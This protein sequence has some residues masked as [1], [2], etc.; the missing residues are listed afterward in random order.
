MFS[1]RLARWALPAL[2]T[3]V[4][5]GVGAQ[6][7]TTS[8]GTYLICRTT[9]GAAACFELGLTTAARLNGIGVRNGTTGVVRVRSLQGADV[10]GPGGTTIAASNAIT[11]LNDISFFT[12]G[13]LPGRPCGPGDYFTGMPFERTI[14]A[15]TT[16]TASGSVAGTP[17]QWQGTA[18]LYNSGESILRFIAPGRYRNPNS[19]RDGL[20]GCTAGEVTTTDFANLIANTAVRTCDAEGATGALEMAFTTD[21][22]FDPTYFWSA[23][24]RFYGELIGRPGIAAPF[25]CGVGANRRGDILQGGSGQNCGGFAAPDP[26]NP[27]PGNPQPGVV[28]EPS[29]VVLLASGLFG[30]AAVARRRRSQSA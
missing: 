14:A 22:I 1:A 2:L 5:S 27:Q 24:I 17:G 15:T 29:S 10:A 4:T 3:V 18:E 20:G 16:T 13:C 6:A 11:V 19:V 28:P 25:Y 9:P 21:A 7:T 30:L 8:L 26:G 12:P 23:N